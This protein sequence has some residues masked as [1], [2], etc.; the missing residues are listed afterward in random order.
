MIDNYDSF[1]HNL[2]RYFILAGA[3]IE[4][5]RNDALSI[6]DIDSLAPEGLILSPGPCSP[7][8]AGIC[9]QAIKTLGPKMPVFGVCLGHQCIGEAYGGETLRARAPI[10]GK[11]SVLHHDG[12]GVFTDL[13]SPMNVGRYHSLIVDLPETTR[14]QVNARTTDGD[15]MA[16]YHPSHPVYGVQFH[17]ESLLTDQ[18]LDLVRNFVHISRQWHSAPRPQSMVSWP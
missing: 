15:I 17:P 7:A 16:F 8:E 2:A 10:H 4:I 11:A 3:A 13:P 14:L 18:G 1:V 9:V 12:M 6:A 5:V